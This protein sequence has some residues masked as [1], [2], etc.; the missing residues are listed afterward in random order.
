MGPDLLGLGAVE[1]GADALAPVVVEHR[2]R[3]GLSQGGQVQAKIM[4]T[5]SRSCQ[6]GQFKN[7]NCVY[8]IK[9]MSR[10]LS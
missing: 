10:R 2:G 5:L 3:A 4:F 9:I 6:G 1:V 8:T 7:K